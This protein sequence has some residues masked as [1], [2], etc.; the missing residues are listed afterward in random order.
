MTGYGVAVGKDGAADMKRS[1]RFM[2][3]GER[4]GSGRMYKNIVPA[5]PKGV[6][7]PI[8]PVRIAASTQV[9]ATGVTPVIVPKARSPKRKRE[10]EFD[11]YEQ[12]QPVYY[13]PTYS[14]DRSCNLGPQT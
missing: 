8:A 5:P 1:R 4:D 7:S 11:G 9:S 14:A 12:P 10:E 2:P 6:D 3:Y 13:E